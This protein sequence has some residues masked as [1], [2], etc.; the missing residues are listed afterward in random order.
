[1]SDFQTC[2][3]GLKVKAGDMFTHTTSR[4]HQEAIA[5]KTKK[6]KV[7]KYDSSSNDKVRKKER[8]STVN[9]RLVWTRV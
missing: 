5:E 7:V 6:E 4:R 3:C 8:Y 2:S 1:M 9:G